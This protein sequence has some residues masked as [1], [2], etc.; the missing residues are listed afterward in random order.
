VEFEN[1]LDL[2]RRLKL[3][4]EEYC[5][6]LLTVLILEG[7]YPRWNSRSQPSAAGLE[8]LIGLYGRCFGDEWPGDG[9]VFVD[10]FELPPRHDAERGGAPDYA[11]LWD[12]R[13]WLIELKTEKASHR[14]GQIPSYFDLA[15]HHYPHAMV[16]VL[17]LTPPMEAPYAAPAPW[18]RY[19]HGTWADI[20]ELIRRT[21]SSCTLPGQQAVADGLLAALAG[22]DIRPAEWRLSL[23]G[24]SEPAQ[25][26][27]IA[28]EPSPLDTALAAAALTAVDGLQRAVDYDPG[29][30]EDLLNLRLAVR[31]AL[32]SSPADSPLR[33]VGPWI[34]RPESTGSALTTAGPERGME[35]RLSRYRAPRY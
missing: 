7:P 27:P 2:L 32:A 23:L 34:W 12:D 15:H 16:D 31:D 26:A 1:P 5:Q 33:H 18:G 14:A 19:S 3:G 6:R 21:W 24:A 25:G 17:Y 22:L 29:D 28:T 20:Q 35:L 11:V 9:A 13:L 30:L 8:F 4:R 10:E